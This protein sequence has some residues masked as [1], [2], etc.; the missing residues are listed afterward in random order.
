MPIAEDSRPLY[1]KDHT[2]D[3]NAR[4]GLTG[5]S[6]AVQSIHSIFKDAEDKD[7]VLTEIA[8]LVQSGA[9]VVDCR[10]EDGSLLHRFLQEGQVHIVKVLLK[11]PRAIDFRTVDKSG[12]TP[13]HA[14]L[15]APT[16]TPEVVREMIG[17]LMNRLNSRLDD[18]SDVEDH[19]GP[20]LWE[21][22]NS[23]GLDLLHLAI[24]T[25]H[26]SVVF[27]LIARRPYYQGRIIELSANPSDS[28][29]FRLSRS[30]RKRLCRPQDILN[31]EID[32]SNP[33]PQVL[34]RCL[35]DGADIL[36]APGNA[37]DPILHRCIENGHLDALVALL[38][39]S[40]NID[41][42]LTGWGGH[43]P[44]HHVVFYNRTEV[45]K[46]MLS[47][48]VCRL[49]THP[50]DTVSWGQKNDSGL[51]F[52]SLAAVWSTISS[53]YPL[54]QRLPYFANAEKPILLT[55]PPIN[56]VEWENDW[57]AL[58]VEDR[59]MLQPTW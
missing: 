20:P 17:A 37:G 2:E 57:N 41:F 46:S 34:R 42:T 45:K 22:K 39:T 9:D 51:D 32:K 8:Q 1:H 16:K 30:Q 35:R 24:F 21:M 25:C 6:E 52:L 59:G 27:P 47:A 36:Y 12:N 53:M 43:T 44:L 23:A 19:S 11:T 31:N 4:D 18:V 14:L 40:S 38:E 26:L 15:C 49:T 58:S 48:I 55:N 10:N 28:D 50:N 33:D 7:S 5:S 3:C 54:V 13:F 56:L 29:W